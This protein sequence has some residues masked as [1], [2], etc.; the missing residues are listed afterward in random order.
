[1]YMKR[2]QIY[3]TEEQHGYLKKLADLR[4]TTVSNLIREAITEYVVRHFAEQDPLL[5]LI[6]L[7]KSGLTDGSVHH[8]RDLYDE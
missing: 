7:G 5:D 6:G 3:L 8:D 2:T 4:D 1:M